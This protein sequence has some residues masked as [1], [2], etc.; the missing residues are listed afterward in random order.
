ML[1]TIAKSWKKPKCPSIDELKNCGTFTQ[2]NTMQQKER[3]YHTLRRTYKGKRKYWGKENEVN[4][5]HCVRDIRGGI[6]NPC[7][8]H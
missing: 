8:Y 4:C 7:T 2:W 1:L 3:R 6:Q 5:G